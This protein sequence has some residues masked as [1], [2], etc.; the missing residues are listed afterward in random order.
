MDGAVRPSA[1]DGRP[2]GRRA[3]GGSRAGRPAAAPVAVVGAACRLPGAPDLDAYWDLLRDGR[4]AVSVLPAER[5]SQAWFQ[6]PR[7]GEPGRSY[8]F[9]AGHLGDV[10]LF[11]ARHFGMSPREAAEAD[12]QQRILLE[13]VAGAFDDSGWPHASLAGREVAVFVGGSSTDYGE[14]RLS[15]PSGAD[16]Y[17]MTGNT[18]SI[19][20]NRITNA[21]D[22][23]GM[24]QTVDTACSSALVALSLA[25]DALR[26][27]RAEAAVVAGVQLLLSPY[28]FAGFSK[29]SM[30]SPTGRCRPFSAEADGY[31]RAEGAG[32]VILKPL[33]AALRDG[34]AVRGVILA[35]GVNAVGRSIG[36]SLPNP[37]AQAALMRRVASEAGVTPERLGYFEAHGTGTAVGDP[38]EATAIGA[39][40]GAG[41]EAPLPIGSAKSNVGHLEPAS[42]MA[43]LIKA[44]LVLE[45][46][47][48]PPSIHCER[49]NPRI[50]FAA[51]NLRVATE[52]EP[53]AKGASVVGV[54][55]FGFGGTNASV[56][57]GRAPRAPRRR[58]PAGPGMP[59]LVISASSAE[60]LASLAG[61]WAGRLRAM[62]ARAVPVLLRGNARHRDLL[63]HRIV[64]RGADGASLAAAVEAAAT[65]HAGARG[66][67]AFAF[68]GNGS[69]Y[70]GM[71]REALR[72][73][74]F[75]AGVEAVD[76]HL[77]P[78]LGWSVLRA[79]EEGLTAEALVATE[80]AQPALFAVQAGIVAAL[81]AEGLR[82]DIVYGHSVGEAAT[83]LAAGILDAEAAS[84]LV[85]A[86]SAVQART[87]GRGRM[88]A[89]NLPAEEALPLL[90]E[91]G[92]GL[93][94]AAHNAP[95][96]VTIAGPAAAIRRLVAAAEGRRLVCIELDLDYA[97]HSAAM[98]AVRED[99]LAALDGLPHAAA[100]VPIVSSVTG[101]LLPSADASYWWRNLRE[102]VRFAEAA[103]AAAP[104]AGI[105]VEIGPSA[106]LQ[107]Y[108]R[109]TL[110][111]GEAASV[112][113][114]SLSKRDP[115]GDPIPAVA[116]RLILAGADPRSGAAFAGPA[117]PRGLPPTAFHRVR[118]WLPVTPEAARLHDPVLDHPLLGFRRDAEG[119]LRHAPTW[120]RMVDTALLPWLAD[121]RL[122]G[123][124]VMP[125]A[126][127]VEMALAA[128]A[129]RFPDA[130]ALE[131]SAFQILRPLPVPAEA[132][133]TETRCRLA[134]DGTF[135]IEARRRLSG[136]GWT[137][138]AR[139][140][141]RSA[142]PAAL[143]AVPTGVAGKG[144]IGEGFVE[145]GIVPAAEVLAIAA[146][147]G[148]DYGPAFRGLGEV[149][150]GRGGE[151]VATLLLPE[152]APPDAGFHI[153][154]VRLDAALQALLALVVG[155]IGRGEAWPPGE[156]PVPTRFERLVLRRGAG[157][158]VS[159]RL[160]VTHG[161]GTAGG[162]APRGAEATITLLDAGGRVA[163]TVEGAWFT[164]ARVARREEERPAVFRLEDVP[165]VDP[166]LPRPRRR[167]RRRSRRP[168]R[169]M[170]RSTSPRP[171]CSWKVSRRRWPRAPSP[172]RRAGAWY[173]RP[174][175]PPASCVGWRRTGWPR[176]RA[177]PTG[178]VRRATCRRPMP[179]GNPCSRNSRAWRATSPGW[180]SRR[181]GC[182]RS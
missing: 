79:L 8:T 52:S 15:D 78:R 73:P 154:P 97:F 10:S 127:M 150:V 95:R 91:C 57:L 60:A 82:P 108:L 14:L 63:P 131:V 139:G 152:A 87:R 20:A 2:R 144:F 21:F 31:V 118:H 123:E 117:L 141:V 46:G 133:A 5:F 38:V 102:P 98:E 18:L 28:A 146:R 27:G 30:L 181:S 68:S 11:D 85:V 26:A 162:E 94:V 111:G 99:L 77:A 100:R 54:N 70:P 29:A 104:Q 101:E 110:R 12:P 114:P 136:E 93:E 180:R 179:S 72:N 53:L 107:S 166:S 170:T 148:L 155:G 39:V 147:A 45:N 167:W 116:D 41:R 149:S 161:M 4:D 165:A 126:G 88:A 48:V 59:P 160:R 17:F 106:I 125:A 49:P 74:A 96:A 171:R 67:V 173:P 76:A 83:A 56:L 159:A 13:V 80:V 61:D 121:H 112:I 163:A 120:R 66:G 81:E 132:P 129:H 33:D 84:R 113:L 178:C 58:L 43:G 142:T 44:L 23:R 145:D 1:A 24:A 36:L 64:A 75:R 51:L 71:A 128:A 158:A 168:R 177:R 35:A 115:A 153:H 19:L 62:P 130:P 143:G 86:R 40:F 122:G 69:Q 55:S 174:P 92:P 157:P 16:R 176:R 65:G 34:D 42:G 37:R 105:V 89:L 109:E 50:D 175:M 137:L 151:A 3:A 135:R 138:H 119:D 32:A 164:R 22:L 182:R 140:L 90:A 47:V 25:V 103:L 124:A 7:K 6:H 134:D 9:A 156:A 172:A 169:A